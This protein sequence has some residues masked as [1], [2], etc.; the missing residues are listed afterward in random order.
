MIVRHCRVV[1][2][3]LSSALITVVIGGCSSHV[4]RLFQVRQAYYTGDLAEAEQLLD[5]YLEKHPREADVLRLEQAMVHLAQGRPAEAERVLREVRDRFDHL[6]QSSA[7]EQVAS[8]LTDDQRLAYAGEDYEKVL[9]RAM[10]AISSLL[11]DGFDAEAYSL[12]VMEKQQEIIERAIQPDGNNPK[13]R[14]QQVALAPYIRALLREDSHRDFDDLTRSR[15]MVVS[16]EPGFRSGPVDLQRAEQGQHSPKG[17]GALYVFALVGRG[18]YK[19]EVAE[20]PTTAALLV[21]DRIV[22]HNASQTL[23]PTIAPIKVPRVVAAVNV[24]SS[25]DVNVPGLAAGRTDTITNVSRMAIAQQEAVLPEIVGRAVARRVIKKAAVYTAKETL[26]VQR[27]SLES[28][29]FD[30]AGVVWEATERADT[31][32]WGL[33]PDRIQVLRLELP[34]GQHALQ[35]QPVASNGRLCGPAVTAT[36]RI[37]DGRNAYLLANFPGPRLVGRVTTSP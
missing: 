23:P 18:P 17:H 15:A 6:E 34:A 35:L 5:K 21:A 13:A 10:L 33:L 26:G 32:C 12:Q 2:A 27:G 25:V 28:L 1:F 7:A 20:I 9:L 30:V 16:W 31:R 3:V 4:D 19:E 8:M 11:Q 37:D 24:V 36:V 29:P 22:S 14:Y